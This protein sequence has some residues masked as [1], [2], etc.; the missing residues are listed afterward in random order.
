MIGTKAPT[1]ISANGGSLQV[2]SWLPKCQAATRQQH[3]AC[4]SLREEP[5]RLGQDYK[6]SAS[7]RDN[8][9]AQEQKYQNQKP[10]GPAYLLLFL[11]LRLGPAIPPAGA[12]RVSPVP[13]WSRAQH[14]SLR[15]SWAGLTA[16]RLSYHL[17]CIVWEDKKVREMVV[18]M[19]EQ[20]EGEGI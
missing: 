10:Q 5:V 19:V 11:L 4:V 1:I 18:V 8:A 20:C 3:R 14:S 15:Q 2:P 17:M 6:V 12:D 13:Q 16:K 7:R 9:E